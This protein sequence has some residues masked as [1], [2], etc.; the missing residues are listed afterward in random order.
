MIR[1]QQKTRQKL[2]QKLQP[3]A[4]R[5]KTEESMSM[6][7][8]AP[9]FHILPTLVFISLVLHSP[10]IDA[11]TASGCSNNCNGHGTCDTSGS[12]PT[13]KCTC[14]D[15]WGSSTDIADYKAPDCS[16]R[17]CPYG[18]RWFDIAQSTVS[19]HRDAECSGIGDCNRIT[20]VCMCPIGYEGK[21]C[22]I[23]KCLNSCSGH[24]R[25]LDMQQYA[26][27][28]TAF[29]LRNTLTFSYLNDGTSNT[30]DATMI[31]GC[32]CDSSW[33]VGLDTGETQLAEWFGPD[34][35]LRRCPSGDDPWTTIDETDCKEKYDNGA[36]SAASITTSVTQSLAGSA[37]STTI[38]HVAGARA[39]AVG[40]T[41]TISGH[42]GTAANTAMNQV[43]T[44]ASVSSPTVA[45]LT[46]SGMTSSGSAYSSGTIIAT[47][48]M[49]AAGNLCH[50]ECANRGLCNYAIGQCQC[51][52]SWKGAACTTQVTHQTKSQLE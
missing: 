48:S 33:S 2:I 10:S 6:T 25:C 24:G 30:W 38:T 27:E 7:K 18:R 14:F 11:Q 34:C 15:G 31:R 9:S 29:P 42:T 4:K 39:F 1:Q 40:D 41:V 35:S 45:V 22:N 21:S 28:A 37:T 47:F 43:F 12:T 52:G 23:K 20:G 8:Y 36:S 51:F 32:L 13:Y 26:A 17:S 50:V 16:S 3:T 46:G 49:A 44:V 19:G 5:D